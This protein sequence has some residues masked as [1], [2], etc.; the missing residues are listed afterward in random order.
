MISK[1]NLET[2]TRFFYLLTIA[3]VVAEITMIIG[4]FIAFFALIVHVF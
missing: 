1:N 2:K 3:A 4:L